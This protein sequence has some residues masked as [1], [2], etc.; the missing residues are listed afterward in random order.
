MEMTMRVRQLEKILI[1]LGVEASFID[2][3]TRQLRAAFK[4]PTG[5]RGF[6]APQIGPDE[7]AWILVAMAGADTAAHAAHAFGGQ[8]ELAIPPGEKPRHHHE[9]VIAMQLLL[10]SPDLAAQVQEVRV[11]QTHALSQIVYRDGT[12][13]RFVG[14]EAR[15]LATNG[16]SMRFRKEGVIGGGMLHQIATDF[17]EPDNLIGLDD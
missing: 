15:H 4:L 16:G 5:G 10:R 11:G 14:P 1:S 13:E 17:A 2:V 9:F 6:N 3:V 7:G 12:V 8:L